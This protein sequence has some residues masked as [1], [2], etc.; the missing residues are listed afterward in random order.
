MTMLIWPI[1]QGGI[2]AA[3]CDERD[4]NQHKHAAA[5]D[6]EKSKREGE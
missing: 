4:H 6:G 5:S 3:V 2:V 1:V